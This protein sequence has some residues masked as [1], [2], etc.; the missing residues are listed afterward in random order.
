MVGTARNGPASVKR[1][2]LNNHGEDVDVDDDDESIGNGDGSPHQPRQ[3][4][5]L[6]QHHAQKS[7]HIAPMIRVTNREFRQ[8]M[9]ILSKRC[10][11]W[12]EMVVDET[13]F[14]CS[15]SKSPSTSTGDATSTFNREK[16][17]VH[18]DYDRSMEHPIICQIGGIDPEHTAYTSRIVVDEYGY[19]EINLNMDCPSDRVQGKEFGAI[20]MKDEKVNRACEIIQSMKKSSSNVAISVKCRIGIDDDENYEFIHQLIQRL[21]KAGC[22]KFYMHARKVLLKG[23]SPIQNRIVPPLNYP[24]IYRLCEDFPKIDFYIN[25]GISGLRA[26]KRLVY[27][28]DDEKKGED[29]DANIKNNQHSVP[30]RVCNYPNGSCI[31]PPSKSNVPSNLR[32]CMLGR[33]MM[34]NP[35][36]LWDCDRYFYG[37]D[38]NPCRTRREV[39]TQYINYL[40][41][42]Y[43][44]R[45]CDDQDYIQTNRIPSP[46]VIH[47]KDYCEV[48]SDW[49]NNNCLITSNVNN[50]NIIINNG[51]KVKIKITSHVLQRSIRPILGL[52]FGL[53]MSKA[54]RRRCEELIAD[55]II[56]NCGP[57][58]V[59]ASALRIVPDEVLD[60]EFI[61]TEDLSNVV[62]HV[63]PQQ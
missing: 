45:C 24:I 42:V 49:R 29:K 55:K 13:I 30:C 5:H 62:E 2:K 44:R 12:T 31:V 40:E 60:R 43:P 1:N 37:E 52:F 34:D 35:S 41:R 51:G 63:S 14:Y 11:L 22:N 15:K 8:L 48:C 58:F 32:G 39:L 57:A 50:N 17:D 56:R 38:N 20:L 54:F 23:L 21:H 18:L 61:R 9:R 16:V 19:D 47:T 28:Y 6:Q 10:V 25:G 53:S 4:E 59:L 27:G 7:L 3:A 36:L 26:A 33:A 46:S